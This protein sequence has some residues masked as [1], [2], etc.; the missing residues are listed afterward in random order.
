MF[1][2]HLLTQLATPRRQCRMCGSEAAGHS[3]WCSA[4]CRTEYQDFYSP[5]H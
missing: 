3:R 1:I 4:S 2:W 5:G